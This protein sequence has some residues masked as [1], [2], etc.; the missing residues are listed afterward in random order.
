MKN[1]QTLRKNK[2]KG[3]TLVEVIVVIVIVAILMASLAPVVTGWIREAQDTALIAEGTS[4]RT[5]VTAIH[6][7]FVGRGGGAAPDGPLTTTSATNPP[8]VTNNWTH[9][10]ASGSNIWNFLGDTNYP[11]SN[12]TPPFSTASVLEVEI[13]TGTTTVTR[14]IYQR[15]PGGRVAIW[16]LAG[17]S[18][19]DG[20]V[21][22]VTGWQ[23]LDEDEANPWSTVIT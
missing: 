21:D 1:L 6:V 12:V 7:D 14:V 11:G 4:L 13:P 3:F 16:S 23:V 17:E 10:T 8:V 15:T 2:K 22:L 20:E 9:T 19:G 5:A 18:G